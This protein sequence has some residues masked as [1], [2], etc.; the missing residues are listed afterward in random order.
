MADK[1]PIYATP[2]ALPVLN[3]SNG[4]VF[5][6][7]L[8]PFFYFS[9]FKPAIFNHT[10]AG[11][12]SIEIWEKHVH[13]IHRYIKEKKFALI[14]LDPWSRIPEMVPDDARDKVGRKLLRQNYKVSESI[15]VSMAK[16]PGG[17]NYTLKIWTPRT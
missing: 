7:G 3:K 2:L 5:N 8:G 14:V 9:R 13:K 1:A 11:E 6:N 15:A 12:S 17:G 4:E 10:A 16:R